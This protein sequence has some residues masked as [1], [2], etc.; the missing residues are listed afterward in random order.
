MLGIEHSADWR[1]YFGSFGELGKGDNGSVCYLQTTI[2]FNEIDAIKLISDIPGSEEWAVKDLFQRDVDWDRVT[3]SLVDYFMDGSKV[4][5]FNPLTLTLLPR[6]ESEDGR[7]LFNMPH[8]LKEDFQVSIGNGQFDCTGYRH[9]DQ[10]EIGEEVNSKVGLLRWH[11]NNTTL[12]A[13]DG[14][15]RLAALQEILKGKVQPEGVENWKIPVV[16][17]NLRKVDPEGPNKTILNSI[18]KIFV[19]INKEAKIP[20]KTRLILL[21]EEDVTSLCAQEIVERSHSN[22]VQP[23]SQRDDEVAP[24]MFFDWKGDEKL[25]SF[26][27]SVEELKNNLDWFNIGTTPE[28][29]GRALKIDPKKPIK[30]LF[31]GK[32]TFNDEWKAGGPSEKEAE[33]IRERFNETVLPLYTTFFERFTPYKEY[34]AELRKLE[35]LQGSLNKEAFH[36]LRFGGY[37]PKGTPRGDALA[38]NIKSVKTK[39]SIAKSKSLREPITQDVFGRAVFCAMSELYEPYKLLYGDVSD[40]LSNYAEWFVDLLNDVND[41]D[42]FDRNNSD[43]E[44]IFW[45]GTSTSW[46]KFPSINKA[47]GAFVV[48]A[49]AGAAFGRDQR[50]LST[51]I[52]SAE[53][54]LNKWLQ[55]QYKRIIA[56]R[57]RDEGK[58]KD[59]A[60][61]EAKGLA[62]IAARKQMDRI[63]DK[64]HY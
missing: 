48:L 37:R 59:Q 9:K 44:Y 51:P 57:L 53:A 50:K 19:Y 58:S 11:A 63:K 8:L 25:T 39:I 3:N 38:E 17:F 46:Y 27:Y 5:F 1:M 30:R 45:D 16:I 21:D 6:R 60:L 24:L 15:H 49:I 4:K 64:L 28:D 33:Q 14:Q 26:V 36:A 43:L 20:S 52:K 12:V 34:I 2:P 47:S 22:D 32:R 13:I 56:K 41:N 40:S 54:R 29:A 31:T 10:F 61:E 35:H 62:I 55:A 7:L 42:V 23:I 18:R